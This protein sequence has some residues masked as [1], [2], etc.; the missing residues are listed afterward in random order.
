MI[1]RISGIIMAAGAA[2]VFIGL[3][4]YANM[5]DA[6]GMQSQAPVCHASETLSECLPPL[7]PVP[8]EAL[9]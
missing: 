1:N 2:A 6:K 7:P 5:R 9:S 8:A 4:L 3:P